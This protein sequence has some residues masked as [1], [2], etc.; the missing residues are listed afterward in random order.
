LVGIA[1][2]ASAGT[3]QAA[4]HGYRMTD[5]G[6]LGGQFSAATAMND[7]GAVVG[8]S[9]TPTGD[10]HPFVWRR[11]RMVD[12]GTLGGNWAMPA[13]VN[14]AGDVVGSS[15]ATV[16]GQ[17]AV[18]WRN[19]RMI[20]IGALFPGEQSVASDINDRGQVIGWAYTG[21]ADVHAFLWYRGR[22]TALALR[23]ASSINDRGA[24][25]GA[26]ELGSPDPVVRWYRGV[27]TRLPTEMTS[28]VSINS[29]GWVVGRHRDVTGTGEALL[30]RSGR[31]SV[32]GQGNPLCYRPVAMNDRG[33]VLIS[34]R[35]YYPGGRFTLWR[36]GHSVELASRGIPPTSGGA[37]GP[38][39]L[40]AIDDAGRIAGAYFVAPNVYHAALYR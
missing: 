7:R 19:G 4:G 38:M 35:D 3:E 9:L 1:A 10:Y 12:L 20:D 37:V 30:W 39:D 8:W 18:L 15:M 17:H 36:N 23:S 28:A 5:L 25:V 24:I 26:L 21:Y 40:N 22:V 6:T 31:L 34:D 33:Q 14:N 16:G 2:P 11:G 27:L 13:A 32:L 29:R